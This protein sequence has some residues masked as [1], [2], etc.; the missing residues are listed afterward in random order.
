MN[1]IDHLDILR[2]HIIRSLASVIIFAIAIFIFRDWI[3]DHI[4]SAPISKDFIS[5]RLLCELGYKLN[6]KNVLCLPPLEISM[7][8]TTFGGQF[9]TSINLS[10]IGGLIVAFPYVFWEFWRFVK[11]GLTS[12][13]IK[14]TRFIIF[15]VSFF[16][17][18]GAL[19]GYFVLGP[20][21][22]NFL[23]NFQIGTKNLIKN[24]PTF[25]D[26]IENLTNLILGCGIAFELPV[27]AVLLTK[28][29][30]ITPNFL[31][32]YRKYAIIIILLL[33]A[34]ITPSPDWISQ[35]IVFLP[36][37]FLYE[38]SVVLS[39]KYYKETLDDI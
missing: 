14:H 38:L 37:M 26:Y 13:E 12:K 28:I 21:T 29:G 39:K 23:G 25:T 30:I 5:Y 17:F 36:L 10:L 19:F 32:K 35:L 31:I 18:S 22:F 9:L 1:F 6:L 15:W 7:Q 20:F 16:F 3:M 33:A 27:I 24:I 2:K 34:F 11:P 8:S 4:I